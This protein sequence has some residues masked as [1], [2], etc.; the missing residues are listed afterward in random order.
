MPRAT[1]FA[2]RATTSPRSSR[3]CGSGSATTAA[4]GRG[5]PRSRHA[6]DRRC[7]RRRTRRRSADRARHDRTTSPTSS[8][9]RRTTRASS[10]ATSAPSCICASWASRAWRRSATIEGLGLVITNRWFRSLGEKGSRLREGLRFDVDLEARL[11]EGAGFS[12]SADGALAARIHIDKE[13]KLSVLKLTVHSIL[14][15]VPI[16]ATQDQFD[17]RV[18]V[19]PHWSAQ[20]GSSRSS[21]TAP[22]AGSAGGP[23]SPAATRTAAGCCRRPGSASSSTSRRSAA[24]ASST[25]GEGIGLPNPNDRYAGVLSLRFGSLKGLSRF[26]GDRVRHPRADRR[27]HRRRP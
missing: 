25:Y 4:T 20:V 27:P 8:S 21:S 10:R 13:F 11:T 5:T 23:T 3:A 22:A 12:F 15:N 7:P 6:R 14:V 1:R 16:H 9:G 24:A 18:E 17:I 19:R 2:P 26:D